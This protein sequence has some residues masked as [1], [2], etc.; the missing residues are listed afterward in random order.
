MPKETFSTIKDIFAAGRWN[1]DE[2]TEADIDDL[3]KNFELLSQEPNFKVPLKVDFFK[4]TKEKHH[5][6]QPAVGWIT[7]LTKEGKKL[8]AQIDHIPKVV[9]ELIEKKAY[10]QVSSEIRW[11]L[12]KGE[13]RLRRVLT[14]VALLGV[15]VPGVST[16][17]EFSALYSLELEED[18]EVRSYIFETKEGA[19]T[20]EEIKK[21]QDEKAALEKS[22]QEQKDFTTKLEGEKKA[23]EAK[24]AEEAKKAADLA[25]DQRKADIKAFVE[26]K[27][28][29]GKILP[30]QEEKVIQVFEALDDSKM[31]IF[32]NADKK[33]EQKSIRKVF[34]ELFDSMPK[35]IDFAPKSK[36]GEKTEEFVAK[37]ESEAGTKESQEL[38]F[39]AKKYMAENKC[40]Y[41]DALVAVSKQK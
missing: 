5:G 23:A 38:A 8:F 41:N 14:G 24:L 33:E 16:L 6:G 31:V 15:E 11:N 34:E 39:K 37:P 40:S 18:E 17:E 25:N 21:L 32:T 22:L 28:T 20:P 9:K 3:I 36:E 2:Y 27:K 19:M 13:Q 1:G 26:L 10:R 7:K 30:A 35:I 12:K 4:E 29:E